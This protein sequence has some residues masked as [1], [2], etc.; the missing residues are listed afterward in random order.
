MRLAYLKGATVRYSKLP[1]KLKKGRALEGA[2]YAL[3][4]EMELLDKLF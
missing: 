3:K 4:W 1:L 2:R